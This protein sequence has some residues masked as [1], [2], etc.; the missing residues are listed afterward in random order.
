MGVGAVLVQGP[1][2]RV[3]SGRHSYIP[4]GTKVM[5]FIIFHYR[6]YICAC[7]MCLPYHGHPHIRVGFQAEGQDGNADKKDRDDTNNLK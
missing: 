4:D 7:S 2:G 1:V 6:L 5:K 3:P